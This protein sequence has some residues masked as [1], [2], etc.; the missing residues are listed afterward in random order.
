MGKATESL[1]EF[2]NHKFASALNQNLNSTKGQFNVFRIAERITTNSTSANYI[3][4]D[5]YKIMLFCGTNV[6]HYAD[7]SIKVEG[8]T[9]LFF[10][11]KMPYTYDLLDKD[12]TGYF[13]VFKEDFF[14]D[15]FRINLGELPL[16]TAGSYPVFSL[17]DQ[18]F[19]EI[20]LI[21]LKI[22]SVIEKENKIQI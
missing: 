3:R 19:Q 21:F 17:D 4:R 7:R 18:C 13:C 2:Y 16:F 9:L 1:E 6:F 12:T 8:N 14:Q 11:P 5:F 22:L 15:F 20:D 10:N